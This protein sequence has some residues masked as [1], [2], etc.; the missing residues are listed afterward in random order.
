MHGTDLPPSF[1]TRASFD[2]LRSAL[3]RMRPQTVDALEIIQGGVGRS[4]SKP[5]QLWDA[6]VRP[7]RAWIRFAM[8]TQGVALG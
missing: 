6:L 1:E 4:N 5:Q 2:K 8:Q 3:L 7:F